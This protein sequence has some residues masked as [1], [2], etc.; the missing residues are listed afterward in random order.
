MTRTMGGS[1]LCGAVRF[2]VVGEVQ[3]FYLCHCSRCRK[4]TGSAHAAN[5]FTAAVAIDWRSG[6]ENVRTYRVPETRHQKSF[7]V[8]C[9]S[10]VPSLQVEGDLLMIPAGCIDGAISRRPDAH[11]CLAS[12]ADWDD[13]L[14]NVAGIEGVPG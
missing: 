11:I 4:D 1:C 3:G 12:R 14:E 9:G 10:A 5:L 6:R 13:R 2:D 7:C 8:T